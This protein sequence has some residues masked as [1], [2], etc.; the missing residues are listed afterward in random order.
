[1]EEMSKEEFNRIKEESVKRMREL[2]TRPMPPYPDF[3]SINATKKQNIKPEIEEQN[4]LEKKKEECIQNRA[5]NIGFLESFNLGKLLKN[6]DTLLIL[7]LIILLL[8]DSADEKLILAL[9]F[10][11][12]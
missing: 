6:S 5:K 9:L 7:G 2:Y 1:M 11:M 3:I 12:M 8:S 4:H 10:I